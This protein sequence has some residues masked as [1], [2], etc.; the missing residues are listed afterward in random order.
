MTTTS[1]TMPP[2]TKT[3][4]AGPDLVFVIADR[5]LAASRKSAVRIRAARAGSLIMC[6]ELIVHTPVSRNHAKR[7]V[8]RLHGSRLR[9]VE[10]VGAKVCLRVK[11]SQRHS[12]VVFWCARQNATVVASGGISVHVFD[13]GTG[14]DCGRR[15]FGRHLGTQVGRQRVHPPAVRGCLLCRESAFVAM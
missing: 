10:T 2:R 1:P 15:S 11:F 6:G 9:R 12:S 14:R 13:G 4:S 5:R 7:P 8:A 3:T